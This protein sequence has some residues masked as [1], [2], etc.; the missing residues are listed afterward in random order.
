MLLKKIMNKIRLTVYLFLAICCI[1][2]SAFESKAANEETGQATVKSDSL[3]VF[4]RTS[5]K[6]EIVKTLRKGDVV[7]VE[8]ELEGTEG[9][10]CGII[11]ERETSISGYVQCQYLERQI[12]QKKSWTSLG[13]SGPKESNTGIPSRSGKPSSSAKLRPYSDITVTLYMTSW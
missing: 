2:F 4:S 10:W 9:A 8:F 7:T 3:T 5:S 1:L 12:Q 6:S 11:E 13:S